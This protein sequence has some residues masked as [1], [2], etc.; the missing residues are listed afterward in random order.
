[1]LL[2]VEKNKTT[3]GKKIKREREKFAQIEIVQKRTLFVNM[4][5]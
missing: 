3:V 1:M 5:I 2:K 4:K